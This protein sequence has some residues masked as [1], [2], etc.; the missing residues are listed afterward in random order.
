MQTLK[1]LQDGHA[2]AVSNAQSTNAALGMALLKNDSAAD[3]LRIEYAAAVAEVEDL[4]AMLLAFPALEADSQSQRL[5]L[6]PRK[7]RVSRADYG[8]AM[9]RFIRE[10]DVLRRQGGD[11]VLQRGTEL[12]RLA[13]RCGQTAITD[14]TTRFAGLN[15]SPE[16]RKF[17]K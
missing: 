1:S 6:R 3:S 16:L 7:E 10:Y 15:A 11:A 5:V 14:C 17:R 8:A 4:D 9:K 13:R 2:R 12:Y